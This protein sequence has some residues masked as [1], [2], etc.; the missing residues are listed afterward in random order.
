MN[1]TGDRRLRTV[2]FT[3]AVVAVVG[4]G[5]AAPAFAQGVSSGGDDQVVL[6]GTL[7]VPEGETV[8]TAVIFN[9]DA[10]IQGTVTGSVVAFNGDV[11]V[12]GT[13]DDSVVAFNGRVTVRS[14]G[15]VG[16]DVASRRAAVIEPGATVDGSVRG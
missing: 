8:A 6:T 10:T 4:L 11:D 7:V 16:G 13:V 1:R 2:L 15:H 3:A 5:L 12:S 14:G 9:G